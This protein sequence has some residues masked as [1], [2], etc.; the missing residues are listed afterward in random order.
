MLE[1]IET[2]RLEYGEDFAINRNSKA[3]VWLETHRSF[4]KPL[5]VDWTC[6]Y[7]TYIWK[8]S[9]GICVR[10]CNNHGFYNIDWNVSWDDIVDEDNGD[11]D[12]QPE[13]KHFNS[14]DDLENIITATGQVEF[15]F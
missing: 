14:L 13:F 11:E 4:N 10:T 15:R 7:E 12:G 9:R 8:D 1:V 3:L 6:N 5:Y 2:E